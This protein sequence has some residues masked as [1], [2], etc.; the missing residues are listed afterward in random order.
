MDGSG[1]TV[2]CRVTELNGVLLGLELR[3]GADGPE[4]FFLHD[5]HVLGDIGEDCGLNE[6]TFLPVARATG[7][8]LGAL[9]LARVDVGHDAVELEL[10]T[11][12]G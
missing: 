5:L 3:D 4:D 11:A 1:K 12:G 2:V 9:L 8:D 10:R 7:F 6:V